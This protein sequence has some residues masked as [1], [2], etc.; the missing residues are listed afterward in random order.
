MNTFKNDLITFSSDEHG[1]EFNAVI[2]G[3]RFLS[4]SSAECYYT[5]KSGGKHLLS[6]LKA[7]MSEINENDYRGFRYNYGDFSLLISMKTHE[8]K[9]SFEFLPEETCDYIDEVFWPAPI[10]REYSE[11]GYATLPIMQGM[12]IEDSEKTEAHNI[13][14]GYYTARDFTMPWWGQT[15]DAGSYMALAETPYDSRIEY[16]HIP[17][18]STKIRIVWRSSL[19]EI[20]YARKLSVSFYEGETGYVQFCKTYRAI[21]ENQGKYVLWRIKS[22]KIRCLAI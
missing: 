5:D 15:S 3:V 4:D 16:D 17:G 21:L 14:N 10:L 9:V 22:R 1:L 19:G 12:M 6:E 7:E 18:E 2:G 8:S 13:L 20:G 11:N